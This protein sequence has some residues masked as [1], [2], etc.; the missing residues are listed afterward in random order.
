MDPAGG[1]LHS[2]TAD[3]T[4]A[5]GDLKVP[6]CPVV[7]ADCLSIT[8]YPTMALQTVLLAAIAVVY[9]VVRY[10]NRTDVPKIKGIPEIPGVPLFGNL[11]QLGERHAVVAQKWAKQFGPV[12]Q[13]RMGNKVC[14]PTST[15]GHVAD[16]SARRLRQ[17]LRLGPPALD[18]RPECL[19]LAAHLPHLPQR[20][21]HLPGL[22]HRHLT[23]G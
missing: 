3:H 17:Q 11:L 13:V 14:E 5:D 12:F 2:A 19:D 23:V 18:Q 15:G 20:R 10:F 9:F 22:H 8:S 7:L 1:C 16:R 21:V 6:E 4:L